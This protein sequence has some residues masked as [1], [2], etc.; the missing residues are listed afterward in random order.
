MKRFIIIIL[1]CLASLPVISF[2]EDLHETRLNRGLRSTE[3]YS[4][5]LIEKAHHNR[6]ESVQLL[7]EAAKNSPD[8]P[9]VYFELAKTSFSSSGVFQSVEYIIEGIA[10][11]SRNFWSAFTLAGSLFFSIMISFVMLA[12]IIVAIRFPGDIQLF[13]HD[14]SE[15]KYLLFILVLLIIISII[16]PFLFLAGMLP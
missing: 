11:Y 7:N 2:G 12:A 8:L 13:A 5:L 6:A 3:T 10:A 9:A 14:V 16:S 1:L 15:S 4:Y